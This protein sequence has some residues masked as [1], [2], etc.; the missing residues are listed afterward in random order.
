MMTNTMR[1]VVLLGLLLLVGCSA[2]DANTRFKP[3]FST[4]SAKAAEAARN[5]MAENHE[6]IEREKKERFR[7][8]EE[9]ISK[10]VKKASQERFR[11]YQER[12]AANKP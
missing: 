3:P 10:Q 1:R 2:M 5:V 8:H 6:T 11:K 12:M 9:K 7:K 4:K